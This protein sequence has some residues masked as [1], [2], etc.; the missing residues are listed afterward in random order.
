MTTTSTRAYEGYMA[1]QRDIDHLINQDENE[2]RQIDE[3]VELEKS[4]KATNAPQGWAATPQWVT[5]GKST[6]TVTSRTGRYHTFRVC[7]V[8][9]EDRPTAWFVKVL[10]GPDNDSDQ[11]YLYLGMLNL[12]DGAMRLT[13]ASKMT[14]DSG[15]VVAARWTLGRIWSGL[16]MPEGCSI[17]HMGACGRCGRPLTTP[18]SIKQGYGPECIKHVNGGYAA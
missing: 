13:K 4:A 16:P 7:K 12:R 1:Q 11:S 9:S 5:A 14:D 10:A 8:E 17:D 6:F 3:A 15:P 18:T 2:Q